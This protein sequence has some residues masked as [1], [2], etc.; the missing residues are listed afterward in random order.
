MYLHNTG[1]LKKELIA[2]CC[3]ILF[4]NVS[5]G[6][7]PR[8]TRVYLSAYAAVCAPWQRHV[9]FL[10][11]PIERATGAHNHGTCTQPAKSPEPQTGH[12][13]GSVGLVACAP[14]TPSLLHLP[15]CCRLAPE[16]R[17]RRFNVW[18]RYVWIHTWIHHSRAS[19]RTRATGGGKGGRRAAGGG[20]GS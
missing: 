13:F 7:Q 10:F 19:S 18:H 20:G 8:H 15:V 5:V 14:P 12:S 6:S 11:F 3:Q 1:F 9:F 2:A 4:V 16:L 17:S